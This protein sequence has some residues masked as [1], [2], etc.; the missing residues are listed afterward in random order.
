M[1]KYTCPMHLQVIKDEP[2][3]CPLCGMDLVPMGGAKKEA[4]NHHGHHHHHDHKEHSHHSENNYDKHEGHHTHDFLKRFWVSLIITVPILLLSHM[5]Q[6]WL[7]FSISFPGGKYVLLSLGTIIYIYGGMPFLKGMAGEIKAKA[8]GMM[9]LVGIAISV[10]YIYSVAVVF[11]LPGMDFFWELATLIVIMLLGHWLEMRSTM[12]ASKALQ[13]LVALLP[14]DVTVERNGEA[15]KIKLEALKNGETIIIKPGEKIP[16]DGL[17]IDGV[18][19]VNES[20]LTGES[21]PVKKEADGKV[22][23]G[24]I[25]GEGALRVTTTGV[26]KDSYLNKVINLVQD[27]QAAKSNTQ[28]LADKV[29]KWLTFIAI[30]VGVATFIYWYGSIEDIAFALERMVTVMVTACPHALGVAIPLVVAISTTLSATNGLLIRNRTA[31]ETTRKLSTI[32]FDKT[33]TLTKGSHAIEKVIPLTDKYSADE[34]IQYAAAVQQYSEHHIAKGILK[35]LKERNLELWK[36]ENFSYMAGIGVK[37][38]VNGKEV[39]AAGPNYFKQNNLTEPETPKEINQNIETVNYVFI[40]NE[41][42]GIITLADSIRE[43]SQ[44]AIDELKKMN[45]KSILLTGDN[46]K[47]AAAVSKQLGMDGFIANVLPHEKQEKVK[48]YQAK[49]EIV[50]MTGDGVNDAPALAQADVG[51]AV[52]SGTDVAAETADIILVNS[53][54]RDVVKMIDFGKRTYKK[55]VQNLLWAVGYNVIAI[56]LAA[57]ILYPNFILSPAMGAVLMSVSTIVVAI[58][59]SL[60]KINK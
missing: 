37:A 10:A 41:V 47:I 39:V 58:N 43:G 56:P 57:G 3:K 25:N 32:I 6:E 22:I 16:A 52:G 1:K 21:V 53:D 26:G 17:V 13:S 54:P 2:G 4:H 18:S 34:I 45:I 5:I 44:Q 31:F 11:G 55:M 35:T 36:S 51:I 19:Y 40:D 27:A 42:I 59:A 28:N 60:L 14:N 8:I 23:A 20:M 24:A 9:T 29:A 49:G 30:A 7:G 46:E 48:E 15:I 33:G 12:A 38:V 50:A